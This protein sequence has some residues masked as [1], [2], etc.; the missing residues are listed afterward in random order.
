MS[1]AAMMLSY[2][3]SI[4]RLLGLTLED[5]NQKME[6]NQIKF[7]EILDKVHNKNEV[8]SSK[9]NK[10]YETVEKTFYPQQQ[11]LFRTAG[12]KGTHLS[13]GKILEIEEGRIVI[14]NENNKIVTRSFI[15]VFDFDINTGKGK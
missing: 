5:P 10:I 15:D 4:N 14:L 3:P 9:K 13:R 7:D 12:R 2:K 6:P 8:L 1:P 11:I